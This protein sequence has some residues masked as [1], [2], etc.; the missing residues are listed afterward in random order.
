MELSTA[1]TISV[2]VTALITIGGTKLFD[3]YMMERKYRTIGNAEKCMKDREKFE[4][5][6]KNQLENIRAGQAF[7]NLVLARVCKELKIPESDIDDVKK[8]L[9]IMMAN[10]KV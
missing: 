3:A 9:K 2:G 8:A 10:E 7:G 1:V 6:I 4:K 5:S